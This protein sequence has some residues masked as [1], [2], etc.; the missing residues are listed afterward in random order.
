M[1]SHNCIN[2]GPSDS[3]VASYNVEIDG[4]FTT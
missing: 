1:L 2:S 3:L 4:A